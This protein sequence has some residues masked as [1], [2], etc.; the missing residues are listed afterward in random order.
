MSGYDDIKEMAKSLGVP[1]K[2]LIVLARQNDPYFSGSPAQVEKAE[3]LAGHWNNWHRE[4]KHIRG[5]HYRLQSFGD[6]VMPNEL[7][8]KSAGRKTRI[9]ENEEECWSY[10]A[11]ITKHARYLGLVD[12]YDFNDMR[13]S[14]MQSYAYHHEPETPTI[15]LEAGRWHLGEPADTWVSSP[16]LSAPL[17]DGYKYSDGFQKYLLALFIEKS[18]MKDILDPVCRRYGLT[19]LEG[20]GFTSITR[21]LDLLNMSRST[22]KPVRVFYISDYDPAGKAMPIAAARQLQFW[23]DKTGGD[24]DIKLQPICLTLKQIE[25]YRLPKAPDSDDVE[26]D[27]LDALHP[28]ELE[29]I[30]SLEIQPYFDDNLASDFAD[31]AND[32]Q[33][34]AESQWL[35]ATA[36]LKEK[37]TNL[38]E[39]IQE[40]LN[41]YSPELKEIN[42]KM[43]EELEPL[44]KEMNEL[45][46]D[47][48]VMADEFAPVLPAMPEPDPPE[49]DESNW[50]YDSSR[51]YFEQV[52]H[53]KQAQ[54]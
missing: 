18:T 40:V 38:R 34:A 12:P 15:E 20:K 10:L 13:N 47:L 54:K 45:G 30:V 9:Y 31:T 11:P 22:G 41:K 17:V 46:S 37:N 4:H 35:D 28:G 7:L 8:I 33:E 6:V 32:A 26:L 53:F 44:R 25:H 19:L 39:R 42:E 49:Q 36:D 21:L 27:A 23:T 52:Q 2:D 50:L 14:E 51:N 43:N 16:I 48:K 24:V 1:E 3:W 29:K 5:L